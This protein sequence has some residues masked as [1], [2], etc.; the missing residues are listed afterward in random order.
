MKTGAAGGFCHP[1]QP[2]FSG[3]V[4][5]IADDQ[6]RT[7]ERWIADG[8]AVF[9]GESFPHWWSVDQ[10]RGLFQ[11]VPQLPGCRQCRRRARGSRF[12]AVPSGRRTRV[13]E[14][15]S[16]RLRR[17]ISILRTPSSAAWVMMAVAAPPAPRIVIFFLKILCPASVTDCMKPT[18]SRGVAGH[19]A[20]F[21]D[22]R[23]AGAG[24]PGGRR[25]L[26]HKFQDRNLVGHGHVEAAAARSPAALPLPAAGWNAPGQR[27][28][29]HS[30]V[31]EG[32]RPR[33]A[34][35]G[36]M[37]CAPLGCRSARSGGF[38]L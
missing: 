12:P 11:A 30:P 13:A 20:V 9:M 36:K 24:N 1:V 7:Q 4:N 23:I 10:D 38:F 37:L 15:A 21:D 26:V 16:G 31:P 17:K 19:P 14:N 33:C 8:A 22:H 3:I 6:T 2:G 35:A 32:G 29:I 28:G 34:S 18:P 27:P 5:N 25:Q